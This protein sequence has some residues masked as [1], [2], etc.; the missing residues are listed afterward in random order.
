MIQDLV[1]SARLEAGHLQ[2][3]KQPVS[4]GPFLY[5]LLER[6][7]EEV[8][9]RRIR[10]ELPPDL[11][12][13]LADPARLERIVMSLL[14]NVLKYSTSQTDVLVRAESTNGVVTI[15]VTDRGEGIAQKDLP[16]IFERFHGARSTR[17]VQRAGLE[18]Y[19][20]RMLVEAHGGKI[21][22]KSELGKG[23]TFCFT[24]PA[25]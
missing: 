11:S 7:T 24:L 6:A 16:H 20:T 12:P 1:D 15:S 19:L 17:A 8:D 13:V 9:A 10:V 14:S 5:G 21:W 22:V 3:R 25:A 4:L 23:S 2:L 18:L